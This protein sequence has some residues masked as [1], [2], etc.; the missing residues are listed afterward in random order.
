MK[1]YFTCLSIVTLV[2]SL[3]LSSQAATN[4][5]D[6]Y[7]NAVVATTNA[8]DFGKYDVTVG[9]DGTT[10]D[11]HSEGGISFSVSADPFKIL[12]QLWIGVSQGLFWEP[13]FAGSTDFDADWNFNIYGNF[14]LQPGWSA[15]VLYSSTDSVI[16]RTGPEL[17]AQ[18]YISDDAYFYGSVNFDFVNKGAD[19]LRYSV[20]I[21]IE[22]SSLFGWYP[23]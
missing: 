21:G 5:V 22:F 11:G 9:A 19:G 6:S 12:P 18:Y 7:T 16:L 17:I 13:D 1:N 23:H 4:S 2:S 10:I 15:G 14:Y 8:P 20:G 3:A